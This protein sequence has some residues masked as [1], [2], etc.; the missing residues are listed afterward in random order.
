MLPFS[1]F[2]A[3]CRGSRNEKGRV[4]R[5]ALFQLPEMRDQSQMRRR[6]VTRSPKRLMCVRTIT[7]QRSP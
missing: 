1:L 4:F 5:A 3:P 2:D 7:R 6:S